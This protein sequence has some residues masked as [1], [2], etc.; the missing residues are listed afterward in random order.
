ML[1]WK[2]GSGKSDQRKLRIS[3]SRTTIPVQPMMAR[4]QFHDRAIGALF[5]CFVE[6]VPGA[7]ALENE[8]RIPKLMSLPG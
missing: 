4:D 2:D 1:G 6:G 3:S 8:S 5:R 7:K